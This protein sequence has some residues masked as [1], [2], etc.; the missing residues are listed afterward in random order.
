MSSSNSSPKNGDS[1]TT[2]RNLPSWMSSRVNAAKIDANKPVDVGRHKGSEEAKSRGKSH[3]SSSG[4]SSGSKPLVLNVLR[5][6]ALELGAEYQADWNSDCTL[7]VCAFHN[8]PKFRQVEADC[9][10]IVSKDWISECYNQKKLVDIES[11]LMHA[12]KLWRRQSISHEACQGL[13]VSSTCSLDVYVTCMFISPRVD[14]LAGLKVKKK[15]ILLA[16][17]TNMIRSRAVYKYFSII[18]CSYHA[19]LFRLTRMK[20]SV[21]S[22]P[23]KDCFSPS[24]VKKWVIYDLKKTISWLESQEE[25][26]DPSDI[27]MIAAEGI[28]TCLQDAI[29]TLKQEQGIQQMTEQWNYIPRVV[30]EL[31]KLDATGDGSTSLTKKNLYRQAVACKQIYEVELGRLND[32]SVKN[33]KHKTSGGK[34]GEHE[35]NEVA[36]GDTAAYDSDETIEMTQEEI[37]QAYDRVVSELHSC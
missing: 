17:L 36:G 28:L 24:K 11:Y 18:T 5:S 29:D 13:P 30:E 4:T 12:G 37:D 22:D 27:K 33:K 34:M 2:K 35:R 15:P 16:T 32:A 23:A 31:A 21:A 7:L 10:T 14:S 26:P 8:T 3:T 25:K 19:N 20:Q 1:N 9:G 6:Q